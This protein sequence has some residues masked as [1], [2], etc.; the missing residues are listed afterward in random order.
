MPCFCVVNA[1]QPP[2]VKSSVTTVILLL[3][4]N[5]KTP[6][7]QKTPSLHRLTR[8]FTLQFPQLAEA[9]KLQSMPQ[10]KSIQT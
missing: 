3:V 2:R 10:P 6:I 5:Q 8:F 9:R 1:G 4:Y 7:H